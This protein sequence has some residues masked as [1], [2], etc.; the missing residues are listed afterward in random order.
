MGFLWGQ[1]P[2]S[3]KRFECRVASDPLQEKKQAG[4]IVPADITSARSNRASRRR[5][6][7]LLC[8]ARLCEPQHVR[9]Q[10]AIELGDTLEAG[11]VLRVTDPRSGELG[12]Y[13]CRRN[14]SVGGRDN[15][16]CTKS[17]LRFQWWRRIS[18]ARKR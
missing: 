8:G 5:G 13:R 16:C 17:A 6:S 7:V 9:I 1:L 3:A 18:H 10:D 12:H 4:K 2:G 14:C 11:E 15:V